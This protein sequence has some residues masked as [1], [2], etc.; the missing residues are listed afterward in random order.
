MPGAAS[1]RFTHEGVESPLRSANALWTGLFTK[2]GKMPIPR[3]A[4]VGRMPLSTLLAWGHGNASYHSRMLL[5]NICHG[6]DGQTTA[7]LAIMKIQERCALR[8]ER[9]PHVVSEHFE[10]QLGWPL[11]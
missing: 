7:A 5:R 2:L 10:L 9:Y 1:Y 3:L 4:T 11:D 8:N 6:Q